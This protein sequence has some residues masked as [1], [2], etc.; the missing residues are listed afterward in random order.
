[1]DFRSVSSKLSDPT[2]FQSDVSYNNHYLN[3]I[4]DWVK[5]RYIMLHQS[6]KV[7]LSLAA[8]TL[9]RFSLTSLEA[10]PFV[11]LIAYCLFNCSIFYSPVCPFCP[12]T[13]TITKTHSLDYSSFRDQNYEAF[14]FKSRIT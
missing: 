8:L 10:S 13:Y 3:Y 12:D 11:L 6:Q 9:K 4:L 7:Q 5:M 14:P 2:A 1:M